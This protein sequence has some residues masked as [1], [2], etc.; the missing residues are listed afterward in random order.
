MDAIAATPPI[1]EATAPAIKALSDADRHR[2]Q[3]WL[4]EVARL[5]KSSFVRRS[6]MVALRD[7]KSPLVRQ[8]SL[9]LIAHE[10][11]NENLRETAIKCLGEVGTADDLALL[12]EL[13]DNEQ[14]A[15][16]G[17]QAAA[18]AYTKLAKRLKSQPA[19]HD[20]GP[21]ANEPYFDIALSFAGEDREIAHALAT[22]LRRRSLR[23]FYDMFYQSDL[24]GEDLSRLLAK[25]YGQASRF[26]AVLISTHYP[27]KSWPK[28]EL[29]HVQERAIFGDD[30]Y[31]IPV[32]VDS[33]T[34]DGISST[35][36]YIDL[37]LARGARRSAGVA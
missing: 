10:E 14:I 25:I 33:T 37:R 4:A 6:A 17:K 27:Q 34:V 28:K 7:I 5:H 13:K 21:A 26:C 36:G 11:D 22:G 30:T 12:A 9:L 8:I 18:K 16:F 2:R 1:E 19:P 29:L 23:V 15:R 35:V 32:R 24:I 3:E 20:T 31:L